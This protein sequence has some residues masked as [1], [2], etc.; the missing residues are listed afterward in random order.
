[1]RLS[2]M[3]TLREGSSRTK[4]LKL[5]WAQKIYIQIRSV[6][7]STI[8][9]PTWSP[10]NS[11]TQMKKIKASA[12]QI[13]SSLSTIYPNNRELQIALVTHQPWRNHW[14]LICLRIMDLRRVNDPVVGI[15]RLTAPWT[16]CPLM[17]VRGEGLWNIMNQLH[18]TQSI[19][20]Q[21]LI[22]FFHQLKLS[23]FLRNLV[24]IPDQEI[25]IILW[26]IQLYG[27]II[28]ERLRQRSLI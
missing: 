9:F 4:R 5:C 16:R 8:K 26:C 21:S 7:V 1:M 23:H 17:R 20:F 14:T 12:G 11:W 24:Q 25:T 2:T 15:K 28:K 13:H 10:S 27:T 19:R 3:M 6:R 18:T 22:V